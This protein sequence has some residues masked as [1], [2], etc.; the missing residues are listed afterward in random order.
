MEIGLYLIVAI[1]IFF[2]FFVQT[3][4][5]F[6]GSLIALP[7]LLLSAALP[8]AIA[9][10]S[11]FYIFSSFF[12]INKEWK[13]I[14]FSILSRLA[15]PTITG[16]V[17]GILV[18]AFTNPILLKKALG[19][20]IILYVMYVSLIKADFQAGRKLV[21]SLGVLGGFFSGVF[22]TGGP[23]YV[24]SVKNMAM[25]VKTFRATMIGIMG[26]ITLVRIPMLSVSGILTLAHWKVALIIFPVFL[27]AQ[28]MGK[29]VY[30]KINE[31]YFKKVLL[32]LLFFSGIVLVIN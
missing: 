5:G 12:L 3:V 9:Y 29:L 30:S 22:S 13:N 28:Y 27:L 8:D 10:I 21:M 16:V 26:L 17:I 1:A 6:A 4:I 20:F 23:L 7:I 31:F 14:D 25:D 11:I 18:L 2:G 19:I 32:V 15:I 24:I